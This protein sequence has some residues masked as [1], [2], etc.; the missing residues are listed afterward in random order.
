MRTSDPAYIWGFR[1]PRSPGTIAAWLLPPESST[2]SSLGSGIGMMLSFTSR[3]SGD[4]AAGA[5]KELGVTRGFWPRSPT[6][7]CDTGGGPARGTSARTMGSLATRRCGAGS[8]ASPRQ[9]R[10]RVVESNKGPE[11]RRAW[12]AGP[13]REPFGVLGISRIASEIVSEILR[14]SFGDWHLRRSL[15]RAAGSRETQ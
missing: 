11:G 5:N 8:G 1:P 14:R 10:L 3:P 6:S 2:A 9:S 7:S 12:V 15:Q 4:S 13:F